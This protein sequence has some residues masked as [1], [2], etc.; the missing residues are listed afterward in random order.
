MLRP[1][2]GDLL[3]LRKIYGV[4]CWLEA[5]AESGALS[6]LG[7]Y[8]T[9]VNIKKNKHSGISFFMGDLSGYKALV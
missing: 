6:V 5:D 1:G 9:V 4:I 2:E 8:I 7:S 3:E